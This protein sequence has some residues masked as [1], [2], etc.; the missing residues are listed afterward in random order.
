MRARKEEIVR[1]KVN[2]PFFRIFRNFFP[3]LVKPESDFTFALCL[4]ARIKAVV[5]E[6]GK[7]LAQAV[8]KLVVVVFVAFRQKICD[9]RHF[10][11]DYV[12]VGHVKNLVKRNLKVVEK[13][14]VR[15]K[16]FYVVVFK[17]VVL[18]PVNLRSS[19]SVKNAR[20]RLSF[21][22]FSV[23]C[24]DHGIVEMKK[25]TFLGS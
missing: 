5:L 18:A 2:G 23:Q 14:H 3:Q 25:N 12:R 7:N 19:G 16:K 21:N 13:S 24:Y 4:Y 1:H 9:V 20:V 15:R 10:A 22:L 6:V 11:P 17:F 8:Q